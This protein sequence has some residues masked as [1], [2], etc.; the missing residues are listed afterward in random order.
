MHEVKA[1]EDYCAGTLSSVGSFC[2]HFEISAPVV[3]FRYASVSEN[4]SNGVDIW[5][6]TSKSLLS[7]AQPR[8]TNPAFSTDIADVAVH[9]VQVVLSPTE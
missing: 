1:P 3:I 8:Y 5:R 2:L 6:M 9:V 4:S 7:P